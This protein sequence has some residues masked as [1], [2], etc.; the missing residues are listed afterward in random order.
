[1]TSIDVIFI[2]KKERAMGVGGR[3]PLEKYFDYAP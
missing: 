3:S 1:M 2:M